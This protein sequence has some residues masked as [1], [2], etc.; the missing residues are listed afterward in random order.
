ML[1]LAEFADSDVENVHKPYNESIGN[2]FMWQYSQ[3][4]RTY[5]LKRKT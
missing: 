5:A 1:A 4:L 3:W 2:S